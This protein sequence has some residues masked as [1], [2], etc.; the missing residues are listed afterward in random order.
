MS[1]LLHGPVRF[2]GLAVRLFPPSLEGGDVDIG[3][4]AHDTPPSLYVASVRIRP[5]VST[6]FSSSVVID[7]LELQGLRIN[8]LR[9]REG[10]WALPGPSRFTTGVVPARPPG[11]PPAG[12]SATPAAVEPGSAPGD[13]S[14]SAESIR[15]REGTLAVYEEG[16]SAPVAT[17]DRVSAELRGDPRSVIVDSLSAVAGRSELHGAGRFGSGGTA[18]RFT[19]ERL[20]PEDMPRL[21]ALAGA[22]AP[23]GLVVEGDRPISLDLTNGKGGL[24]VTGALTATRIVMPPLTLTSLSSP[25]SY[26]SGAFELGPLGFAAY[27]GSF[28]GRVALALDSTPATWRLAGTMEPLDLEALLSATTSLGRKLSGTTRI[29]VDVHGR[30]ETPVARSVQGTIRTGIANGVIRDFPMLAT[31]NR[32]LQITEGAGNDTRF[33]RLEGT[34]SL[35]GGRATTNDL[36]LVAGALTVTLA[37]AIGLDSQSLGLSG[38]ARF[39]REKSQELSRISKHVSGAKNEQGEVELPLTIGGTLSVPTFQIEIDKILANAAKKE[40][41]RGIRRELDKLFKKP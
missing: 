7:A 16:Q 14:V 31:I 23:A 13:T 20:F 33:E 27:G 18:L 26:T 22:S 8:V 15:I 9:D 17:L 21:A 11:R 25:V 28:K 19:L 32:A 40:L 35:G 39:T 5:R 6:L 36:R 30:A 24:Q 34:F 3:G 10:R 41:Q 12:A 2:G 29:A 38:A 4:A 37:G 1:A